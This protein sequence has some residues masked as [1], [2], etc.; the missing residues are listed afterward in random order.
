MSSL[1]NEIASLENRIKRLEA[2][3]YYKSIPK[4]YLPSH[5][6]D[7]SEIHLN[8]IFLQKYKEIFLDHLNAVIKANTATL[9]KKKGKF[10]PQQTQPPNATSPLITAPKATT[11]TRKRKRPNVPNVKNKKQAVMTDY[12]LAKGH[13]L[14]QEI[15]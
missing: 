10:Q 1:Q 12:F 8:T 7:P 9:N 2:M 13:Q 4:K 11:S 3:L 6:L 15:T 5:L 14:Y